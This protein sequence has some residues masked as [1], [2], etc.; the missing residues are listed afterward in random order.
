MDR[1]HRPLINFRSA[2]CTWSTTGA[3]E[4]VS[5]WPPLADTR[6]DGRRSSC[7]PP[8]GFVGH[9]GP[10]STQPKS[11]EPDHH[12]PAHTRT[13][14]RT[15]LFTLVLGTAAGKCVY[16]G[17][18]GACSQQPLRLSRRQSTG[19]MPRSLPRTFYHTAARKASFSVCTSD[20]Q[21]LF[22]TASESTSVDL[23]ECAGTAT[24]VRVCMCLV[25]GAL[26]IPM[27]PPALMTQNLNP[28]LTWPGSDQEGGHVLL[29]LR[30]P[31]YDPRPEW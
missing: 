16:G 24:P 18:W 11:I 21:F 2:H 13:M 8:A 22:S 5:R 4:L 7:G 20:Y 23:Y 31:D 9:A 27:P 10:D 12:R 26:P 14:L 15:V 17:K 19:Q 1:T 29:H 6:D 28:E 30:V 25:G 3:L